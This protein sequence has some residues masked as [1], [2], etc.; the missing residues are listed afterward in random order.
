MCHGGSSVITNL[1]SS[2][3][4]CNMIKADKSMLE[5]CPDLLGFCSRYQALREVYEFLSDKLSRYDSV[6]HSSNAK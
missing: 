1:V 2:C 5:W 3:R 6:T 4:A